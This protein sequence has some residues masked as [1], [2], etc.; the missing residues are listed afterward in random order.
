[1]IKPEEM[2]KLEQTFKK[3]AKNNS[4]ISVEM[5]LII[6]K[7]LIDDPMFPEEDVFDILDDEEVSKT[8]MINKDNFIKLI[9]E[10]KRRQ[11]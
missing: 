1:L 11:N 4:R 9:E 2:V 5:A 6:T 3:L 10:I 7:Q 8:R